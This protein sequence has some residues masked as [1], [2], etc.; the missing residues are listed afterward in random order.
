MSKK[1]DR[2]LSLKR[3]T[4][5][6]LTQSELNGVAGGD[7]SRSYNCAATWSCGGPTEECVDTKGKPSGTCM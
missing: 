3:E 7:R 1:T 4:L 6:Q 2:R 5:R